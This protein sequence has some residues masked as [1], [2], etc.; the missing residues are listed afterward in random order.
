[1]QDYRAFRACV[2]LAGS[3]KV[4][5]QGGGLI[6]ELDPTQNKT[7]RHTLNGSWT[8]TSEESQTT[9]RVDLGRMIILM[10]VQTPSAVYGKNETLEAVFTPPNATIV[11]GD[12]GVW[13]DFTPTSKGE[14]GRISIT[15][16]FDAM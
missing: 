3:E 4:L 2:P 14:H 7:L 10:E 11:M 13:L 12:R 5:G 16:C 8:A 9:W 6:N 1:L 15:T